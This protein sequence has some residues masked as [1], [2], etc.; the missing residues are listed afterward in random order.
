MLITLQ[1][2]I[3]ILSL[4]GEFSD[5]VWYRIVMI[6]KEGKKYSR[7]IQF[8]N[9]QI[10]FGLRN[11]NNPFSTQLAFEVITTNNAKID[12]SL[13]DL[14]GKTVRHKTAYCLFWSQQPWH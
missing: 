12:V 1:R 6:S 2:S 4:T 7:I 11:I 13:V 14:F 5:K 9:E 10:D 8:T 3:I